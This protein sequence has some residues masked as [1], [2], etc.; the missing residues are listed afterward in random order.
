MAFL[1]AVAIVFSMKRGGFLAMILAGLGYGITYASIHRKSHGLRRVSAVGAILVLVVGLSF[2][3]NADQLSSKWSAASDPND[4]KFDA[5][6]GR[7][8]FWAIIALH[9]YQADP[10]TKVIGYGPH[11]TYEITGEQY[12]D[13]IPAHDDWL[14]MLHEFGIVGLLALVGVS[15]AMIRSVPRLIRDC[16]DMA[17]SFVAA[18]SGALIVSIFDIF[19][20]SSETAFFSLLIAVPLGMSARAHSAEPHKP[21]PRRIV[22]S[23]ATILNRRPSQATLNS[24]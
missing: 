6:S 9:W 2:W 20:V 16:P 8:I 17:P 5:G 24:S 13:A 14:M 22:W 15:W 19:C 21:A 12:I 18:L 4:P 10:L 7:E 1:G 23:R 11:S 3:A